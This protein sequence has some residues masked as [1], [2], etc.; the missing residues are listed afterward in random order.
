MKPDNRRRGK[1]ADRAE[2]DSLPA[3]RSAVE[4]VRFQVEEMP[5]GKTYDNFIYDFRSLL[6][7]ACTVLS[8]RK[9]HDP[10]RLEILR[11]IDVLDSRFD[12]DVVFE[13]E[14][15]EEDESKVCDTCGRDLPIE[16]FPFAKRRKDGTQRRMNTCQTCIG[17]KRRAKSFKRESKTPDEIEADRLMHLQ[18][19]REWYQRNKNREDKGPVNIF[20]PE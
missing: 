17:I 18:R 14:D 16:R 6:S 8:H 15:S 5:G 1:L 4:R 19:K 20:E 3:L 10:V 2:Q 12:D 11:A 9:T 13:S 7:C